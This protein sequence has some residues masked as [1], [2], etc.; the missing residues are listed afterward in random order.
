MTPGQRTELA[1]LLWSARSS[2]GLDPG[3][4]V[5]E[6]LYQ[7]RDGE[8]PDWVVPYLVERWRDAITPSILAGWC[9]SEPLA[10]TLIDLGYWDPPTPECGTCHGSGIGQHGDPD[11]SRCGSCGGSGV[12]R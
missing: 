6:V 5:A 11:I 8:A 1:S 10:E 12:A 4:V 9:A 2:T 7:W 3:G